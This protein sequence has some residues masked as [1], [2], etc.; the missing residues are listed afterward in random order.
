MGL[1]DRFSKPDKTKAPRLSTG[2]FSK[3]EI[4]GESFYVDSFKAIRNKL[5]V[6]SDT[7]AKVEVELRLEPGNAHAREGKAVGVYVFGMKV[8]YVSEYTAFAAFN[9]IAI[10][11][12]S[13]S[14][15]GRIYFGDLR[16]NPQKNSVSITWEVQTK[17]AAETAKYDAR[18]QK[19]QEQRTND[20]KAKADFLSNPSWSRIT[21]AKGDSVTFTGF[22]NWDELQ[23]LTEFVIGKSQDSK[24]GADLLVIHPTMEKDSAKLRNW[25]AKNKPVTNLHTFLSNNLEFKKYFNEA[26]GEFEVPSTI[27]GKK[28]P[29]SIPTTERVFQ[30]DTTLGMP[31]RRLLSEIVLLPEQTLAKHPSFTNFGSFQFRL[32]DIKSFKDKI[33][34]LF[35][36]VD[37]Q[38]T[39][40]IVIKGKLKQIT[41]DLEERI[42]FEFRGEPLGFIPKNETQSLLRDSKAWKSHFALAQILWDSKNTFSAQHDSALTE[43]FF[44]ET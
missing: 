25:L 16:E 3:V 40:A 43:A 39:D 20:E 37:G 9:T 34:H 8:G 18:Y 24:S 14:F 2:T 44:L 35:S 38:R 31:Y 29:L 36:E 13:M 22:S 26:S 1:F 10:K 17:S 4:V 15:E 33:E 42:I 32:S 28:I 21:V 6:R 23:V 5:G 19:Q 30:T 11:G 7:E 41:V 27:T 12:D